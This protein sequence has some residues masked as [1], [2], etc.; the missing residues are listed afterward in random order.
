[1]I[2]TSRLGNYVASRDDYS[3]AGV[4]GGGSQYQPHSIF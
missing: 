2:Q 1:M 3:G 4:G